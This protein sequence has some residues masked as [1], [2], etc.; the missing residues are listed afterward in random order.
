MS[1]I[2]ISLR[3]YWIKLI[4]KTMEPLIIN[5]KGHA[6]V[7]II[8]GAVFITLGTYNILSSLE[9][10]SIIRWITN[11]LLIILGISNFTPYSGSSTTSLVPGGQDLRIRWRGWIFWKLIRPGEVEKIVLGRL[12]ILIN[13]KDRKPVRLDLD[14]FEKDQ[15]TRICNFFIEYAK[16]KN[17]PVE[18]HGL[19]QD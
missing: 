14:S 16:Q 7:K 12:F 11:I 2:S 4:L 17:L 8:V 5:R 10:L 18:R 15:K 13:N 1:L 6:I 9:E 3:R 19:S